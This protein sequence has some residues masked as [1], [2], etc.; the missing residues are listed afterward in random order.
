MLEYFTKRTFRPELAEG[1]RRMIPK[2][3]FIVTK[4]AATGLDSYAWLRQRS[5]AI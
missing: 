3:A 2:H 4:M 5:F 1:Q